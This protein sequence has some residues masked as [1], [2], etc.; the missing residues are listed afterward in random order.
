MF[1]CALEKYFKFQFKRACKELKR[2][3]FFHH[4]K[5]ISFYIFNKSLNGIGRSSILRCVFYSIYTSTLCCKKRARAIVSISSPS[6]IRRAPPRTHMNS[7]LVHM[8]G[9]HK[10]ACVQKKIVHK[11]ILARSF[12]KS[13]S[14]D[15]LPRTCASKHTNIDL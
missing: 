12:K 3:L 6:P 15:I 5:T 9:G 13:S 2:L 4:S 11:N 14:P 10:C 1:L 8:R 7:T